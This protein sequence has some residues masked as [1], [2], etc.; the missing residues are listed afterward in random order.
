[1]K[2]FKLYYFF[3][4]FLITGPFLP[5]L[6]VSTSSLFFL[7]YFYKYEKEFLKINFFYLFILINLVFITSSL[8]SD[9]LIFSLK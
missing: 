1:M 2:I 6:M 4:I 3:P 9:N 5:D 7:Y 8:N